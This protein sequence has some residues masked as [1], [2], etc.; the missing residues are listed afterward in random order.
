M[1]EENQT[2]VFK[3]YQGYETSNYDVI[4]DNL[5]IRTLVLEGEYFMDIGITD[6]IKIN[7]KP[8]KVITPIAD[9]GFSLGTEIT[10]EKEQLEFFKSIT[11]LKNINIYGFD[12]R[13]YIIQYLNIFRT[14]FDHEIMVDEQREGR[15]DFLLTTNVIKKRKS[16]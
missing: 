5:Q 12:G 9:E 10:S 11:G 14:C 4:L 6:T 1:K 7:L 2:H 15:L 13:P 8:L 16:E 3:V